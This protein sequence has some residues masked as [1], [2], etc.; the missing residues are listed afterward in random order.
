MHPRF[1]QLLQHQQLAALLTR[2][3]GEE[4]QQLFPGL[5]RTALT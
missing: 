3:I 1:E 5:N 2:H 4:E